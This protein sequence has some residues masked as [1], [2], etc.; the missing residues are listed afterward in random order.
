MSGDDELFKIALK[1]HLKGNL[2]DAI[3]LYRG[4][5]EKNCDHPEACHHLGLAY[6]QLNKV[7]DAI[8]WIKQS[9]SK[10]REQPNTLA[11]LAYCLNL[12]RSF[13]EAIEMCKEAI[14]IEPLNHG[15]WANLGNAQA[16]LNLTLDAKESYERALE[17]QPN[18][19]E[20]LYNLANAFH[21]LK[22]F[23]SAVCLFRRSLAVDPKIAETHNNL[24]ATLVLLNDFDTALNE[25]EV[26]LELNPTYA[27]AWNNRGRAFSGLGQYREGL[28]SYKNALRINPNYADAWN[29]YANILCDLKQYEEGIGG[30]EKALQINPDNAEVYN[31]YGNG[32]CEL[33]LYE[34]AIDSYMKAIK[35]KPLNAESW[36]NKGLALSGLR[37]YGEA[38]ESF[39]QAYIID[40]HLDYLLGSMVHA[41]M[42]ICHWSNFKDRIDLIRKEL[43]AGRK[44]ITP[45]HILPIIDDPHLH[46][47]T[48][49]IYAADKFPRTTVAGLN[50]APCSSEEN[51]RKVRIGYFSADF[52]QHAVAY[53][54][55]KLFELH[56]RESFEI[57]G[58]YHGPVT[59]DT[60]FSRISKAFDRFIDIR[61][62]DDDKVTQIVKEIGIDI[63]VD[64]GG[65]TQYSRTAIFA[66]R[67]APIQVNFLGY[68]STM[69]TN[70]HDYIIAD[71]TI[72]RDDEVGNYSEKIVFLPDTYQPNDS[73]RLCGKTDVL[74]ETK[75]VHD[76]NFVFA[77]F[78][79]TYKITPDIFSTW[80]FILRSVPESVL[81]LLKDNDLAA[82][83]MRREAAQFG[84]D[85]LR[86]I[87]LEKMPHAEHLSRIS[88]ADLFLDTFPYNAHTTASDAL[89]MGLPV[90]TMMGTAF[91]SRVAASLVK[92]IGMPELITQSRAEYIAKAIQIA[93]HPGRLLSLKRELAE[94]R[95]LGPLFDSIRFTR[96]LEAAYQLMY[97]NYK[98]G[99]SPQSIRIS[100]NI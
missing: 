73:D 17:I 22:D 61:N 19:A 71:G 93:R 62:I 43:D 30:Y 14:N 10:D 49:S 40:P 78:N 7:E 60:M 77:C 95:L 42:Q 69:G 16:G 84:V 80:M 88:K 54:S 21:Q 75:R 98:R 53:L 33:T 86:L 81:W 8:R 67:A 28:E 100:T 24:S 12:N 68:P 50:D 87:F 79:N 91:P 3:L 46:K 32:L 56:D 2:N 64:L 41:E 11:N 92:S 27:E 34:Q 51:P 6:L 82:N 96:N 63:A 13:I 15:A 47:L 52:R 44:V 58:F 38:L 83:N 70:F 5:L 39:R 48:A 55:A 76:Q 85:S 97:K 57:I 9:L 89:L 99:C 94:A 36:R 37:R 1:Q 45:F 29:N 65:Y 90:L 20:Y 59:S 18:S 26:A 66:L 23:Q 25:T 74:S 4:L 31:N 72:V 35:I